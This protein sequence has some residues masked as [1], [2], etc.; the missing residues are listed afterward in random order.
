MSVDRMF[1]A[2][3]T[4]WGRAIGGLLVVA[5]AIMLIDGVVKGDWV[6]LIWITLLAGSAASWWMDN[7]RR[8]SGRER[9]TTPLT[10]AWQAFVVIYLLSAGIL[11][12]ALKN[13]VFLRIAGALLVVAAVCGAFAFFYAVRSFTPR[14]GWGSEQ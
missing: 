9:R 8:E 11:I 10:L 2:R 4:M 5:A 3:N 7:R 6:R 12:L 1:A 13:S 14:R